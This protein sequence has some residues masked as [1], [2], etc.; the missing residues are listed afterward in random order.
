M[1][2]HFYAMQYCSQP[3]LAALLV[4]LPIAGAITIVAMCDY[5]IS[6]LNSRSHFSIH[7]SFQTSIQYVS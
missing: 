4:V 5:S 1:G 7:K 6:Q 3:Q 2:I